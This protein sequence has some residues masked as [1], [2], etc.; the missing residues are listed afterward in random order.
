M[1][2]FAHRTLSISPQGLFIAHL[3]NT[4]LLLLL[5]LLPIC[6]GAEG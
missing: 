6:G 3:Q 4:N 5:L 2:A 1:C